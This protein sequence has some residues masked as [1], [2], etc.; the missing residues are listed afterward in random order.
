MDKRGYIPRDSFPNHDEC[1]VQINATCYGRLL[2][3]RFSREKDQPTRTAADTMAN[4]QAYHAYPQNK[5]TLIPG[6][7]I[8]VNNYTVQVE[9][10]LSQG[11]SLLASLRNLIQIL[12]D[13]LGGFAHVYLVRTPAPVYN[14]THHVLKR[15]AVASETMLTEVKKE[16]DIMVCL[17]HPPSVLRIQS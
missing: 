12:L 4:Q 14:T 1:S 5:G 10:Y 11:L 13:S 8:S 2:L 7:T 16:V 9:R 15:I 3:G 17:R 6:Q